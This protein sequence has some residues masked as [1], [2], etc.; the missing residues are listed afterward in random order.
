MTA[1]EADDAAGPGALGTDTDIASAPDG[2]T[3][4]AAGFSRWQLL[5]QA[6]TILGRRER[7][8]YDRKTGED[9]RRPYRVTW[10]QHRTRGYGRGPAAPPVE[11]HKAG[12]RAWFSGVHVC[13]S[14][15]HCP[16]CASRGAASRRR[17]LRALEQSAARQGYGIG[18][19]TLTTPHGAGDSCA[20]LLERLSEARRKMRSGR[21][22]QKFR[23]RWGWLGEARTLEVT[24]GV[25]GWHPHFHAM[26]FCTARPESHDRTRFRRELYCL[27][28]RACRKAGLGLP[29]YRHGVDVQWGSSRV[30]HDAVADYIGKWGFAGEVTGQQ[31]KGETNKG[32]RTPWQLLAAA[33][34]DMRARY[35]WIEYAEAF[36]GRN[37]LVVTPGLKRDLVAYELDLDDEAA[38]APG[39]EAEPEQQREHVADI[40]EFT[41]TLVCRASAH[42]AVLD[43]ALE[44]REALDGVLDDLRRRVPLYNGRWVPIPGDDHG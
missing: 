36:E 25:N 3:T 38:A 17:G 24:H 7:W 10:C 16:V 37:Q 15:W 32:G 33:D 42:A 18:I 14:P 44:G 28:A 20:D 40:D 11:V 6:R 26:H 2:S 35:L 1:A 19:N 21:G 4:Y 39:N 22:W 9:V 23:N 30:A 31:A 8:V 13:G 34:T 29:S 27:W 5:R 43:A 12:D 41:W